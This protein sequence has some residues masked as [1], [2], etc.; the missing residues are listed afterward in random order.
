MKLLGD[1]AW[2]SFVNLDVMLGMF[3]RRHDPNHLL[4]AASHDDT[5]VPRS[6]EKNKKNKGTNNYLKKNGMAPDESTHTHTNV[7]MPPQT[8]PKKKNKKQN[9]SPNPPPTP[10]KHKGH[11]H[12][13]SSADN[14][15]PRSATQKIPDFLR[16]GKGQ[17][18]QETQEKV[19]KT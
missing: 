15:R 17:K 3:I 12:D 5:I 11:G 14:N 10:P 18:Q 19:G 2:D 9:P 1:L 4:A 16:R 13:P 8:P 6:V 7:I